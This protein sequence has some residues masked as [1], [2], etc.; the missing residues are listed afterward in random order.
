MWVPLPP[1]LYSPRL[2]IVRRPKSGTDKT[3]PAVPAALALSVTERQMSW[4][5]TV[6]IE[7]MSAEKL[8]VLLWQLLSLRSW[9]DNITNQIPG[10]QADLWPCPR[11]LPSMWNGVWLH[12]TNVGI[13]AVLIQKICFRSWS[14]YFEATSYRYLRLYRYCIL[15]ASELRILSCQILQIAFEL[16][17]LQMLKWAQIGV[18]NDS[19]SH[20]TQWLADK[21]QCIPFIFESFHAWWTRLQ[22]VWKSLHKTTAFYAEQYTNS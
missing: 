7:I 22:V 10:W 8:Q 11:S 4:F 12:E 17:S 1:R 5:M 15:L 21:Y 16:S 13:K 19:L 9:L 20:W 2:L 3:V 6:E 18:S 14:Q